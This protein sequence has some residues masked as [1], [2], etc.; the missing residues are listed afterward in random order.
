MAE[1]ADNPAAEALSRLR[2]A[3]ATLIGVRECLADAQ[4]F[5]N[6]GLEK[7]EE[8]QAAVVAALVAAGLEV[9][10]GRRGEARPRRRRD[11]DGSETGVETR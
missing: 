8:C 11:V 10:S 9:R 1:A 6:R 7:V 2:I 3:R 5:V 4:G